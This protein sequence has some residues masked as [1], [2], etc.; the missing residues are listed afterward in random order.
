MNTHRVVSA[1][2]GLAALVGLAACSEDS[3]HPSNV[4]S[5]RILAVQAETPFAKPA[6]QVPM[7]MLAWDGSAAAIRSDGSHR[8]VQLL[9]L[10]G[11][12]NPAGD[13]YKQCYP[14]LHELV[15]KLGDALEKQQVPSGLPAGV[16]GLGKDFVASVSSDTISSRAVAS[17]VVYPYGLQVVFVAACAGILRPISNAESTA[18]PLG[19][20][21]SDT[22]KQLGR[23]DFEVGFYPL[24]VYETIT[25]TN[26]ELR[27]LVFNA[28][29]SGNGCSS[30]TNCPQ[31]QKCGSESTCIPIVPKCTASDAGDC[32]EYSVAID[33]PTSSAEPATLA[34]VPADE[35]KPESVWVT[36][37]AD[38]GS[39]KKDSYLIND[40]NSGWTGDFNG[41]WRANAASGTQTRIWAVVR[42]N[43]NGVSWR[44][45]DVWV[46]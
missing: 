39:F 23:E 6:S 16:M 33:V 28:V 24:Y 40:T 26:P 42:D 32:P 45:Q 7:H 22:G 2:I 36:Y 35:A 37:Y 4:N 5:L 10:G 12:S 15:G 27:S 30:D 3:D 34:R 43:R 13:D 8:P 41:V 46:Q 18:F 1:L 14:Y 44:Y 17:G 9:W 21:D 31:G 29:Q 11:C 25:N 19:C 20:F 38:A